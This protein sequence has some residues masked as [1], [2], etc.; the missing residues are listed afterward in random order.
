MQNTLCTICGQNHRYI[1]PVVKDYLRYIERSQ[2]RSY[3]RRTRNKNWRKA[4]L[5]YGILNAPAQRLALCL[6]TSE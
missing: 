6:E 3:S 1:H 2:D 4:M 5:T